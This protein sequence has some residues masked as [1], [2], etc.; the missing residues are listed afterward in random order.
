MYLS[1]VSVNLFNKN[2]KITVT[3]EKLELLLKLHAAEQDLYRNMY[4]PIRKSYD[5]LM[6]IQLCQQI[7]TETLWIYLETNLAAPC[8]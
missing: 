3:E 4:P 7:Y 2:K 8:S 5:D 6:H 1:V